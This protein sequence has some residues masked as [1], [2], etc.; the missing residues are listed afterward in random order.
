MTAQIMSNFTFY[1]ISH[2]GLVLGKTNP[3]YFLKIGPE[4]CTIK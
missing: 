4:A 3:T 1:L 2:A